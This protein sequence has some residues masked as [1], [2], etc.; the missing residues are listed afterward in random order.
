MLLNPPFDT[1]SCVAQIP[2]CKSNI[3]AQNSVCSLVRSVS[4]CIDSSHEEP[5]LLMMVLLSPSF[6]KTYTFHLPSD[7][8]IVRS[9]DTITMA[10]DRS[11]LSLLLKTLITWIYRSSLHPWK[12][13]LPDLAN[14]GAGVH[15]Y[16]LADLSLAIVHSITLASFEANASFTRDKISTK[17][18]NQTFRIV[19]CARVPNCVDEEQVSH[20]PKDVP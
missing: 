16:H 14:S 13:L 4:F 12:N 9:Q 8:W 3:F 1:D 15:P 2:S 7:D 11:A 10:L 19:L 6:H 17:S 5:L 20:V 18:S